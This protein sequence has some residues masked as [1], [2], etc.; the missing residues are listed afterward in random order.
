[1]KIQNIA[2]A[3]LIALSGLTSC[4]DYLDVVNPNYQSSESFGTQETDLEE[5]VIACYNRI[6]IEGTYARVGYLI[7]VVAGDE[8]NSYSDN[9]WWR[10]YD[11]LNA[12]PAVTNDD[13]PL[14]WVF[15]DFYYT[16]K[17]SNQLLFFAD[18]SGIDQNSDLYKRSRGQGLFIRAL[19][20]YELACY[21]QNIPL[22]TDYNALTINDMINATNTQDEILDQVEKDLAEAMT[23]LPSC[24]EGGEWASGRATCGAAAGY[25]ARVLMFRHK[26]SEA[27]AVLKDIING[28]YGQ[29]QLNADYG[30]NFRSTVEN[31]QESLWEVQFLDYGVGGSDMEWTPTNNTKSSTQGHA[32]E[33][34]FG[35]GDVLGWN[36]LASTPWLY[37]T[38]KSQ[39]TKDG[40]VD[41]RLYWT[42]IS[43]E[44]DYKQMPG[45]ANKA[46]TVDYSEH[47]TTGSRKGISVAKHTTARENIYA[48]LAAPG[49]SCGVNIR[50]M[51]YSDVL[52]RAAECE[53]EISG[54]TDQAIAW[55]NEVRSRAGLEDLQ[56]ADFAS[57]DALFEQIANV[58]RPTEFGCEHGR[59]QDIIRW[60]WLYNDERLA[61]LRKHGCTYWNNDEKVGELPDSYSVADDDPFS[62]WHPGHEYL[63]ITT[64][65]MNINAAL[66]GN[67]A[68]NSTPNTPNF[69]VHPVV[70][71]IGV[72]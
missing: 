58:E 27:L 64:Y 25:Y 49:L 45:L 40:T 55:I 69:K 51:R 18:N 10:A 32:L 23:I 24:D 16:I 60:G 39:R 37:Q 44:D 22:I 63:P 17:T 56:L 61:Q 28:K 52:L 5:L 8:V 67:S 66:E 31:T 13:S 30:D 20:Y 72:Q 14:H 48:Q 1:M 11:Y 71:G 68:N 3:G 15:R 65:N 53:N 6:R 50:L 41:P 42:L 59:M 38:F 35:N 46:F 29:Y 19:S 4:E 2:L 36:D 33:T 34:V 21:Y 26:Y 70:K 47:V 7:D 57:A 43:Y 54:P 12:S 62:H 9:D